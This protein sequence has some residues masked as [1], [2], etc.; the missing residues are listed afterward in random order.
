MTIL[1][2]VQKKGCEHNANSFQ[3]HIILGQVLREKVG[4][5][6]GVENALDKQ[7]DHTKKLNM[8]WI[9]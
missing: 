4:K 9:S 8:N 3:F 5:T 7:M 6:R 2:T 1:S